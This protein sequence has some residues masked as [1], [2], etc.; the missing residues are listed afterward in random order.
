M[1]KIKPE[2]RHWGRAGAFIGNFKHVSHLVLVFL[3][4][5]LRR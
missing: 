3:F 4:L 5:T 2:Q 1:L